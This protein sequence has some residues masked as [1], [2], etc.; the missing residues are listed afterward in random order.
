MEQNRVEEF[1]ECEDL[2]FRVVVELMLPEV[3]ML[4]LV[5]NIL[6]LVKAAG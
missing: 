5:A 2:V 4:H 1:A 3:M 6:G